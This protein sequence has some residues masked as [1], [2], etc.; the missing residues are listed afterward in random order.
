MI[1]RPVGRRFFVISSLYAEKNGSVRELTPAM[2]QEWQFTTAEWIT[3]ASVVV[4]GTIYVGGV[5]EG[6]GKVFTLEET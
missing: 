6:T 5:P 4:D 2:E 1:R 3:G